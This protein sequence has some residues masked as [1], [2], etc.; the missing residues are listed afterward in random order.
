MAIVS[1]DLIEIPLDVAGKQIIT[2]LWDFFNFIDARRADGSQ[3]S[4][5]LVYVAFGKN[6][7]RLVPLTINNYARGGV[8]DQITVRW[9]ARPGVRAK[10]YVA[11]SVMGDG[12]RQIVEVYAPPAKQLVTTSVGT[13]IADGKV[14]VTNVA[15]PIAPANSLR[16]SL[17][18][19]NLGAT[20]VYV[21]GAAVVAGSAV[22]LAPGATITLDKTT[23]AIYGI[24]AA[25]A[26]DIGYLS[27]ES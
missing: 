10:F 24:T 27:E 18:L 6:N 5:T 8:F 3:D 4:D 17:T 11:A 25:G 23:A 13:T 26:A 9:D 15:T 7:N 12:G 16:Q 14:N 1:N 21:G 20:D 2:G 22:K 19:M